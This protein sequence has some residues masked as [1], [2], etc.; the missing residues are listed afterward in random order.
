MVSEAYLSWFFDKEASNY[1]DYAKTNVN[2]ECLRAYVREKFLSDNALMFGIFLKNTTTHIGNIKFEPIDFKTGTTVMGVLIG[3]EKWRGKGVFPE[4]SEVIEKELKKLG[5][6][7][8]FLGVKKENATAVRAYEKFGYV[9]D[10]DNYLKL[11]L[12]DAVC[13]VKNI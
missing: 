2:M 1:I 4:V 6:K 3:D 11:D 7:K 5:L 9:A 13:M 8:V 12:N 10:S